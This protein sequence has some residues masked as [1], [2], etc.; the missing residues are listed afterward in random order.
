MMPLAVTS[1]PGV[2]SRRTTALTQGSAAARSRRSKTRATMLFSLDRNPVSRADEIVPSMSMT[3]TF[4]RAAL[5]MRTTSWSLSS[6]SRSSRICGEQAASAAARKG[7]SR[8]ALGTFMGA[9][10]G[11]FLCE[12]P[13]GA[14]GV[15]D[16]HPDGLRQ[17]AELETVAFAQELAVELD[18][19]APAADDDAPGLEMPKAPLV[20]A[21]I[22]EGEEEGV[23]ERPHLEQRDIEI[24]VVDDGLGRDVPAVAEIVRLGDD[25]VEEIRLDD[26]LLE[27]PGLV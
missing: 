14:S 22:D 12:V 3:R 19:Q 11:G 23:L 20:N 10:L 5:G 9:S 13:A 1:P 25:A 16:D 2:S 15:R 27:G 21:E 24:A 26:L 8:T 6:P 7:T 17:D 4:S 18:R